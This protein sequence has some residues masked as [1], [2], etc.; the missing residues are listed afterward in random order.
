MEKAMMLFQLILD[1]ALFERYYKKHVMG[2]L[3]ALLHKQI[4]CEEN[5]NPRCISENSL[6]VISTAISKL[7]VCNYHLSIFER[8]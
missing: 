2:R 1:K 4:L 7:K 6:H 8:I 3:L 5:P